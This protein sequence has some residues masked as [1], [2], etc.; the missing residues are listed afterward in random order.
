MESSHK[1]KIKKTLRGQNKIFNKL[2]P[3]YMRGLQIAENIGNKA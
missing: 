1:S 3:Q 2:N